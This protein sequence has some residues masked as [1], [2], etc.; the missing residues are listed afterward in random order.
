MTA[1]SLSVRVR[2]R[3]ME[4]ADIV[5]LELVSAAGSGLPPFS[6]GAHMDVY[7][8]DGLIRQ[9]SLSNSPAERDRYVIGVLLAPDS[10]GGSAQMHGLRE[11]DEI[12]ISSPSNHFPLL[13]G[14]HT[15]LIAGGI[16]ITPLLS[17][18]EQLLLD[19]ADF[20][21]H[22]C[23][24][25]P[26]QV[27]FSGRWAAPDI[28]GR[29]QLH[30]SGGDAARRVDFA[31]LLAKAP[32]HTQVYVCGPGGFMDAVLSAARQLGIDEA[33]LHREYFSAAPVARAPGDA[34]FSV[35]LA[36]SGLTVEVAPGVTIVEA[37]RQKGIEVAVSCEQGVCGTCLTRVTAGMP[38]HRD[39]FLTDEEHALNDQMTLCCSR[40]LTPSLSLDI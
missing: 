26:E 33:R 7:L 40:S 14:A 35:V 4:T 31:A 36:R 34:P 21:L 18:A 23:T 22:L 25:S 28:S 17:M 11:G 37:L 20:D 16:G 39:M 15:T 32:P 2:R 5:G 1:A 13:K 12:R 19:A 10:R 27:P 6:A 8:P 3:T 9:Y 38:D 30:H 29:L 24:R